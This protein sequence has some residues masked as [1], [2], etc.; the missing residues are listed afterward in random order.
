MRKRR[1]A[2]HEED[3]F[4]EQ[5][6]DS[7]FDA[8]KDPN[9]R[10]DIVELEVALQH[11]RRGCKVY[12]NVGRTGLVDMVIEFPNGKL[13]KVD[14]KNIRA[15]GTESRTELHKR[16]GIMFVGVKAKGR[17]VS[18]IKD[19]NTYHEFQPRDIF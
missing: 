3:Y 17:R 14:A 12:R 15:H 19:H 6:K 2:F 4:K 18:Y 1:K 7:I 9:H 13:L 5:F 8:L 16:A 10:G 11:M